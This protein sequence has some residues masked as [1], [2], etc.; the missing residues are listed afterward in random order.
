[1]QPVRAGF[2]LIWQAST[3]KDDTVE[4][5]INNKRIQFSVLTMQNDMVTCILFY[6]FVLIFA[7]FYFCN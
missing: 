3:V 7:W 1:M 2:S 4:Y 5:D 6:H